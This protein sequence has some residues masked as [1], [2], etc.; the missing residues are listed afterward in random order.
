MKR[1]GRT[2]LRKVIYRI[3]WGGV[4]GGGEGEKE[5]GKPID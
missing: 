5:A 2:I 4:G 1:L 3:K